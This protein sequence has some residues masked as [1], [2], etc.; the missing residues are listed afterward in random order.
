MRAS[1]EAIDQ[2]MDRVYQRRIDLIAALRDQALFFSAIGL[3]L[4]A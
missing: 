3:F 2:R 1:N 4:Q